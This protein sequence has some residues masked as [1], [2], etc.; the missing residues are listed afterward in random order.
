MLHS[1][2]HS[3]PNS[4]PTF[5]LYANSNVHKLVFH[6]LTTFHV[7]SLEKNHRRVIPTDISIPC[8]C[9][10]FHRPNC[11]LH[12][13]LSAQ[14][15]TRPCQQRGPGA[16][17]RLR[18][19]CPAPQGAGAKRAPKPRRLKQQGRH[20]ASSL[21]AAETRLKLR[22]RRRGLAAARAGQWGTH[23]VPCP[24]DPAPG[25]RLTS[26]CRL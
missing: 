4:W 1:I 11:E 21:P 6:Q 17:W 26:A 22:Q 9:P 24:P 7:E 16:R 3:F 19:E 23:T 12:N 13:S 25:R 20:R 2:R 18:Q 8:A 10:S 14:F 5:L 15:I